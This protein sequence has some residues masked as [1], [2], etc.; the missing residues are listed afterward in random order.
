MSMKFIR[1]VTDQLR[2]CLAAGIAVRMP[3]AFR[4]GTGQHIAPHIAVI[5]M[6]MFFRFTDQLAA[7]IITGFCMLML[8]PDA[9]LLSLCP[10]IATCI[11]M[12]SRSFLLPTDQNCFCF[13]AICHMRM[14]ADFR[15][16]TLQYAILA[17]TE[18][19][20]LMNHIIRITADL[21]MRCII[22]GFCMFV[23]SQRFPCTD[24]K[25]L[26]RLIAGTVAGRAVLMLRLPALRFAFH[27][28]C[29]QNKQ[30]RCNENNH[31]CHCAQQPI[32]DSPLSLRA[33]KY[34]RPCFPRCFRHLIPLPS[35]YLLSSFYL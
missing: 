3:I 20:M 22:T 5:C 11:V 25:Q 31:H 26:S 12:M 33:Q 10:G 2:C 6:Y 9:D 14:D 30:I 27:R 35:F 4:Y 28:N 8:F 34:S 19:V 21:L 24:Q 13:P 16:C 29:G 15:Q 17:V 7:F 18:R 32:P 1:L 23:D